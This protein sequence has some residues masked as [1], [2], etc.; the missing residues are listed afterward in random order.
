ME[1]KEYLQNAEDSMQLI[2]M[3]NGA[4]FQRCEHICARCAHHSHHSLG[5]IH[6]QG[7]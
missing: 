5:K 2:D 4:H 1:V 6:V 7:N 3:S